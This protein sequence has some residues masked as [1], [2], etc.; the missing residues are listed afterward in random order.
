MTDASGRVAGDGTADD[1]GPCP[2]VVVF[3]VGEVLI[4]ETRVWSVWAELLGLSPFTLH[5]LIGAAIVQGASHQAA[6]D[7]A[8]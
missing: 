8:N 3:D 1:I 5:A 6:L 2:R 4:D 7:F